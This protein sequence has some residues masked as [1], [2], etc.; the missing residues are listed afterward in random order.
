MFPLVDDI[1]LDQTPKQILCQ[2][3][4][5]N[6]K[7]ILCQFP[8][9]CIL[10]DEKHI[11]TDTIFPTTCFTENEHFMALFYIRDRMNS[12]GEG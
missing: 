7:Q 2:K 6:K 3:T 8:M 1:E 12:S 4:K 9:L 5:K 11:Q 10:K